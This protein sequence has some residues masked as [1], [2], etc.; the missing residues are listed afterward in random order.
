MRL[1]VINKQLLFTSTLLFLFSLF[2]SAVVAGNGCGHPANC[3][4]NFTDGCDVRGAFTVPAGTHNF[5]SGI[6]ICNNG[7]T[8]SCGKAIFNGSSPVS[9]TGIS[10][11]DYTGVTIKDCGITR[12]RTAIMKHPPNNGPLTIEN[13]FINATGTGIRLFGNSSTLRSNTIMNTGISIHVNGSGNTIHANNITDLNIRTFAKGMVIGGSDNILTTN[14]INKVREGLDIHGERNKIQTKNV[15]TGTRLAIRLN[16]DNNDVLSNDFPSNTEGIHLIGNGSTINKNNLPFNNQGMTV[17]GNTNE[18]SDNTFNQGGE[19][20]TVRGS[21]NKLL[22]NTAND[23]NVGFTLDKATS[24]SVSGN[25]ANNNRKY[26]IQII[27]STG[28]TI[29]SNTLKDNGEYD[30]YFNTRNPISCTDSFTGNI[31]SGGRPIVYHNTNAALRNQQ[32][33]ELIVC[34]ADTAVIDTITVQGSDTKQN[35]GIFVFNTNNAQFININATGNRHGISFATSEASISTGNSISSSTFSDNQEQGILAAAQNDFTVTTTILDNNKKAGLLMVKADLQQ[36][37]TVHIHNTTATNHNSDGLSISFPHNGSTILSNTVTNNGGGI[38]GRSIFAENNDSNPPQSMSSTSRIAHNNVRDNFQGISVFWKGIIEQNNITNSRF[39]GLEVVGDDNVINDNQITKSNQ[40][41]MIL[42]GNFNNITDNI[43]K[44]NGDGIFLGLAKDNNRFIRNT[45]VNHTKTGMQLKNAASLTVGN[46]V[47]FDNKNGIDLSNTKNSTV[48]ENTACHNRQDILAPGTMYRGVNNTCA[49]ALNWN[50]QNTTGC[51]FTCTPTVLVHGIY[52]SDSMWDVSMKQALQNNGV[53]T[54]AIGELLGKQGYTP[55]NGDIR[56]L[57]QQLDQA[58]ANLS[59]LQPEARSVD[60]VAHSQGGLV[61]RWYVTTPEYADN[62]PLRKLI[63][64]DTPHKGSGICS[65][66]ILSA[67]VGFGQGFSKKSIKD[68][69]S[70]AGGQMIPGSTFLQE[71]DQRWESTPHVASLQKIGVVGTG[72]SGA[73]AVLTLPADTL[74]GATGLIGKLPLVGDTLKSLSKTTANIPLPFIDKLFS[75]P[76]VTLTHET[77]LWGDDDGVVPAESQKFPGGASNY[78]EV[79][80]HTSTINPNNFVFDHPNVT[81]FVIDILKTGNSTKLQ[82][83]IDPVSGVD[84]QMQFDTLQSKQQKTYTFFFDP[85]IDTKIKKSFILIHDSGNVN[86]SLISPQG[87]TI[88]HTTTTADVLRVKNATT[89]IDV[90]SVLNAEKGNWT[91][92]VTA[93]TLTAPTNFTLTT[94][95]HTSVLF[96]TYVNDT[97]VQQRKGV[98]ITGKL[99]R[100]NTT[101]TQANMTAVIAKPNNQTDT[102]TL[103]DDGKHN[104]SLANDGI[105]ANRYTNTSEKGLYTVGTLAQTT[106]NTHQLERLAFSWFTVEPSNTSAILTMQG[107]PKV[108]GSVNFTIFDPNQPN[109]EYAFILGASGTTPGIPLGDNRVIPVNADDILVLS[110]LQP[111]ALGLVNT[112]GVLDNTG[113][114]TVTWNIPNLPFLPAIPFYA[115]CITLNSTQK[116]PTAIK[117]ICEEPLVINIK[118]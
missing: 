5:P 98:V 84:L 50:D 77:F 85:Q 14:T 4:V 116:I 57:A 2:S 23:G 17:E 93:D 75:L 104:D 18:L 79:T 103:F 21:N 31:G 82:P 96:E 89:G 108:G 78:Q 34:G 42:S 106:V 46:N 38:I 83:Y 94:L 25:T 52:S 54:Y 61:S 73:E 6:D 58:I 40:F 91:A 117:S 8:L 7:V 97:V 53:R 36:F 55:S 33:A 1:L 88:N 69:I 29:N 20:I 86:L 115:S 47:L 70:C 51:T 72:D 19:G 41:G 39:A 28:N 95:V 44:E 92:I 12:Y 112:P 43:F 56:L 68:D 45:F 59:T 16:G 24:T 111:N 102:L 9:G 30:L 35:N 81:A 113:R 13:S 63:T 114:G 64:L 87:R 110:F 107:I 118:P 100:D 32:V 105:F 74:F 15:I 26:G 80:T 101:I 49:T 60:I 37:L 66:P 67:L 65:V 27:T 3:D 10:I 22:R 11:G 109:R 99:Q 71:L 76:F 62:I 90:L 48:S